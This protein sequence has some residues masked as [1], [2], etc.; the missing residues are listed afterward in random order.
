MG[1]IITAQEE[2]NKYYESKALN[3]STLKNLI[4]GLDS[5][6]VN[7]ENDHTNNKSFL[8][9]SAVDTLLTAQDGVFRQQYYISNIENKP[10]D[11]EIDIIEKVFNLVTEKYKEGEWKTKDIH[12]FSGFILQVADEL[13]WRN[14]WKPETRI[15]K[16]CEIGYNYFEDLKN[17]YGKT[18][19]SLEEAELITN[20][21]TSLKTNSLTQFYFDKDKFKKVDNVEVYYQF[22]IYFE[23]TSEDGDIIECKAL[24]DILIV[25]KDDNGNI[26]NIQPIDLKTMSGNTLSFY[27]N[28]RRFRYD[29][30]AAWYTLALKQH[31]KINSEKILPFKFIVESTTNV[32]KPLIYT[33][34]D[35]LLDLGLNGREE[36]LYKNVLISKQIVGIK[37]LIEEFVYYKETGF[38]EDI[39]IT[40]NKGTLKLGVN[41]IID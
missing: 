22:P 16:I 30:Q 34:D 5:F 27:S 24:L 15:N 8:I 7:Q 37:E 20:I 3:Q 17:S 14:N 4:G 28:F 32:G 25:Y 26:S 21:V 39:M 12:N 41:G 40:K 6:L 2:I 31:F 29:I 35:E 38:Q 18:I 23:I 1:L 36:I 11:T 33:I 19:L 9:G 13:E 10:S